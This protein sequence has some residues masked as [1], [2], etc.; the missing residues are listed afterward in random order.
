MITRQQAIDLANKYD[1]LESYPVLDGHCFIEVDE[2]IVL[3]L[4]EASRGDL[5]LKLQEA[6]KLTKQERQCF[7]DWKN[8]T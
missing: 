4:I 8:P 3:A 2:R 5:Y 7:N 6:R 1:L